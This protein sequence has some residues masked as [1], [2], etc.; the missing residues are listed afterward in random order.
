[1]AT[2]TKSNFDEIIAALG[3]KPPEESVEWFNLLVY[4]D[5]GAGKTRL[6]GTAG[7]DPRTGPI[8]IA[9]IE[10][11]VITLRKMPG[12]FVV[13]IRTM[14]EFENLINKLHN[15]PKDKR[16]RTL[17][18]DGI[19]ELQKLDMGTVMR[20]AKLKAKNPENVD[21]DVP[22]PR[23]WGKSGER[24]RRILRAARDLEMH[25]IFTALEAQETDQQTDVTR[26]YPSIP[27][28][29]K[30][31]LSGFF[32]VVGRLEAKNVPGKPGEVMRTLQTAKTTKVAAKDRF[33]VLPQV[34]ENPTIPAMWEL[35]TS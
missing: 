28:K 1:M 4:G 9:D 19:T 33:D 5:P 31:E 25:T 22:S 21:I 23:E 34:M 2:A 16:P 7:A 24:L 26:Y 18:I 35:I 20:E 32:D 17:G 15:T 10:G 29:L 14:T 8:I 11:G 12:I 13:Q 3:A 27:G 30:N 6:M